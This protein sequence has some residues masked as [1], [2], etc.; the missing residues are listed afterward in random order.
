MNI[1]H[2]ELFY[3]VVVHGGVSQAA[4]ALEREQPTVSKQVNDLEDSLRVKL[5]QRRPFKLTEKGELL[6]QGLEPFFRE[7]P[8]LELRVK[9]TDTIRIGAS[10]IVLT[11]H[12]PA[13]VKRVRKQFP[14]LHLVLREANQPQ[15]SQW[16]EK[17]EIDLAIT[18]LPRTLPQKVFAKQLL[19]IPMVLLVPRGSTLSSANALWAQPEVHESLICLTPDEMLCREFQETLKRLEV[20]WRPRI[21]VGSLHLVEHY[22]QEGYGIGL[23]VAVPG[24]RRSL[25]LRALELTGF[26][27]L[28]LG[29]LWRDNEDKL[30]RAFR[31]QVERR[32]AEFLLSKPKLR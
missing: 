9:G 5:Y 25:K 13:V 30:L 29:M 27:A 26:P 14:N 4:K 6:F 12:L 1:Y 28:P 11:D 17:G 7:L 24:L 2:L 10:P 31:E 21:E 32:A 22:V 8:K 18:L 16:I 15:L 23:S 3:H 20:E 19:E